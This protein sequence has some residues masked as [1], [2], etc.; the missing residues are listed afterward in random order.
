MAW[1]SRRLELVLVSPVE[2][3]LEEPLVWLGAMAV[4]I[5]RPGAGKGTGKGEPKE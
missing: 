3:E 5:R 4:G 1:G 2:L